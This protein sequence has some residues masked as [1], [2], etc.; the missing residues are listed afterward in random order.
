MTQTHVLIF[1]FMG[2]WTRDELSNISSY[3]GDLK[4]LQWKVMI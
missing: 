4:P 1:K 2:A 3:L